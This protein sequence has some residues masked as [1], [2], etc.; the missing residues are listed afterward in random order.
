MFTYNGSGAH[1]LRIVMCQAVNWAVVQCKDRLLA[2]DLCIA[3]P[4]S[5]LLSNVFIKCV[6]YITQ[7]YH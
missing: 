5:V 6:I 1:H 2:D 4:L 3:Q 7:T